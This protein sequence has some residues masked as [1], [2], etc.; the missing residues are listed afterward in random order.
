MPRP[1]VVH[2][3]ML[4]CVSTFVLV[5][6][7]STIQGGGGSSQACFDGVCDGGVDVVFEGHVC[8][9]DGDC[10]SNNCNDENICAP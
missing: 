8:G 7:G 2:A 10:A 4:A 9:S 3:A 5:G 6:C 1:S